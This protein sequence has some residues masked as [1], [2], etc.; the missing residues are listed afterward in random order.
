VKQMIDTG[1]VFSPC[2]TW[3]YLLWRTWDRDKPTCLFIGLNPSTATETIDDPTIK[4]CINFCKSWGFGTY[5]MCNLYGIRSTDPL[6]IKRAIEPVGLDN[7]THISA[8]AHRADLVVAAWGAGHWQH[9][10]VAKVLSL[11][12]YPHCVGVTKNGSPRHPLYVLGSQTPVPYTI[13]VISN[14]N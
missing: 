7:D 11:I 5:L 8:A 10:R 4:R 13:K 1:A 2:R 6:G 9:G 14:A 3:R 12:R